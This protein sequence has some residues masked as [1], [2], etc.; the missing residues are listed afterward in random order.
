MPSYTPRACS[1]SPPF[2][3]L[4]RLFRVPLAHSLALSSPSF[5]MIEAS[6]DLLN[7]TFE[8]LINSL[9]FSSGF[10]KSS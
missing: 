5:A 7:D 9:P 1:L 6:K 3:S 4:A 8:V 10:A 2:G